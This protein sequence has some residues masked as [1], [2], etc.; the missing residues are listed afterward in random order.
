MSGLD[1]I[2]SMA[3]E[4]DKIL[5]DVVRDR[6]FIREERD[7]Y[8]LALERIASRKECS[9]PAWCECGDI[10]DESL[11]TRGPEKV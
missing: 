5:R 1:I 3:M 9:N 10:A 4:H 6:F 11:K 2:E 8:K 7:R